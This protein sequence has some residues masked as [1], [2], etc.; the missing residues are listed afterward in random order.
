MPL[1]PLRDRVEDIPL[2]V[3]FLVERFAARI[4]R[5]I[6]GVSEPTMA[7]LSA[8]RWPGNIRELEN[9]LERAV[10]LATGPTLDFE[11]D[12]E[13]PPTPVTIGEPSPS[14]LEAIERRHI[15]AVLDRT[16]WTID[17]PR[18]AAGILGLHP[19]T[20]RSRLKKLGIARLVPRPVVGAHDIS[21][22]R[23][24]AI[25]PR[26]PTHGSDPSRVTC[27]RTARY[28]PCS[29]VRDWRHRPCNRAIS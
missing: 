13:R 24:A 4:G 27:G 26:E 2:L 9:L 19:N 6:E 12:G 17:G 8:Y 7:R 11:I 18:G 23:P 14:S 10:I 22:R 3:H 25:M 16:G 29:R 20:L 15:L 1:P 21:S 28:D 5:R